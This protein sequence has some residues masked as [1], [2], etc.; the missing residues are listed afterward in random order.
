MKKMTI[1]ILAHVDAGKTT[2][3]ESILYNTGAIRT[4]GRVDKKDAFL[5]TDVMEKERG[6]TIFSKQA[7]FDLKGVETAKNSRN[8]ADTCILE[9]GEDDIRVTLLDTPGHVDFSP[10]AERTLWVLDYAIL[11]VSGADG[12]QGHTKTL[13][14][15]LEKYK[16]PVFIFVNKMDQAGTDETLLLENLKAELSDM[17]IPFKEKND[18]F[19]EEV[20]MADEALMEQYLSTEVVSDDDIKSA[21]RQRKVF[22]VCF[23]SAL[24]NEG[25]TELLD[26]MAR[27]LSTEV[28]NSKTDTSDGGTSDGGMTDS[29]TTDGAVDAD[30]N[31]GARV[32]KITHEG[33]T[34]LTH[35][36]VSSGRL[37]VRDTL[38]GSVSG[39]KITQIRVYNGAK[40]E[41]VNDADVGGVYALMGLTDTYGGQGLGFEE[42]APS[43]VLEPVMTYRVNL[44][45]GMD[46]GQM[47]PKLQELCE[48][49]PEVNA[50]WDEEL[51]EIHV[52]LMGQVQLEILT[53]I[54]KDRYDID[55]TFG[56]GRI[57]YKETI[58]GAVEGIGHFEPL[59]HYAEI[60]LKI[61]SG[62]RGS[63]VQVFSEAN[64][65]EFALNWQ[66]L[67]MTHVLERSHRGVLTGAV[68]TDI[69]VTVLA[70]KA[71]TKHTMGGDF[72]QATYRAIRQ[73]LMKAKN[74]LLEPYYDFIL[75]VPE[76]YV[77]RA[78]TDLDRR[79]AKFVGPELNGRGTATI[80]GYA[81]VSVM[82]D[83]PTEVTAYSGGKGSISFTLRGYDVCH[84]T[85]EIIEQKGYDP[86]SDLR[87][88]ADSVFCEHGAGTVVPWNQVEDYIHVPL[89]LQFDEEGNL[90]GEIHYDREEELAQAAIQAQSS[91]L[92][93]EQA[94]GEYFMGY[95][96]VDSIIAQS[97]GANFKDSKRENGA[98]LQARPGWKREKRVTGSYDGAMTKKTTVYKAAPQRDK[99]MLVDGYNV[100]HAWKELSDIAG[101]NLDGARGRLLDILCNYQ[102]M[103]G[104]EL[105]A[106]F[107]AYKVRGQYR[108]VCDYH[109]IHVVYTKEAETADAYI[110]KFAH[111]NG[112]KYDITVVTS[113]GVEQVII[114]G[115]GCKLMSS[116]EFETEV[117]ELEKQIREE[118][119][120]KPVRH[121]NKLFDN[122]SEESKQVLTNYEDE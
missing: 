37:S 88:T 44:P 17:C 54:I 110:E 82:Q 97:G 118:H 48:D 14:S 36:K 71:H 4:L 111:D 30:N 68:V 92:R 103:K 117:R 43:S 100:I 21:I 66:R 62:E 83:Y 108:E 42:D 93:R 107:D 31:F 69:K 23:G 53:R 72:R 91:S 24:K 38:P 60:H 19:Y 27:F 81:P 116:R 104:M 57:V 6:I 98:T 94:K 28:C 121:S 114:M 51:R 102:A 84:N 120:E 99:Y 78:M 101:D 119:T 9:P 49:L 55:V 22:P 25:V 80:T 2:L 1:G 16:V 8:S 112:K 87:N 39:E 95:E 105:I 29:R 13:F 65:D 61:E 85:E 33:A 63:G 115:A 90:I 86:E 12:V 32:F 96:E 46:E 18:A 10:E 113:D 109:N 74:I 34:R 50:I 77:G 73:G 40:Y 3:S 89:Q 20:S 47:M 122:L 11:V 5:D 35:I 70:G 26:E 79:S 56:A 75:Q 45:M 106:V 15:L 59:R 67:V 58:A 41:T 64:T 52:S 7:I 76:G